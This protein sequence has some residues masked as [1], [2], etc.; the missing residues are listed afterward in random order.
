MCGGGLP[1][2][3]DELA[4]E[5]AD[6]G[7]REVGLENHRIAAG[8]V[9]RDRGERLFHGQREVGVAADSGLRRTWQ[10]AACSAKPIDS[11]QPLN[12]PY[13]TGYT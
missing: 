3:L 6:L 8:E 1:E 4:V 5:V 11:H 2:V 7:G 9:D 12:F 10:L 13:P